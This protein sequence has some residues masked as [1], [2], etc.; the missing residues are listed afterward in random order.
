[1]FF[2]LI[3]ICKF[4]TM[5]III[6]KLGA[7]GDVARTLPI[8]PAL[9]QKF[10]QSE[11]YWVTKPESLELF[12]GNPYVKQVFSAPF[13]SSENFD[14]LCNF[15]I[16]D[17]ATLLAGEIQADKKYGFYSDS[18]YPAPFNLGSQYYL[19]TLFDD[20]LKK[21]N[22]K[23][24]Q[25]MIFEVAELEYKKQK[26]QIYL[27]EKDKS[28]AEEFLKKNNIS[29]ENLV[30]IHM[31]ASSRWPSKV[32]H[33]SE[34]SRFIEKLKERG[35]SVLLFGGPNE[36]KRHKEFAERLKKKNIK[37]FI[38]NPRNTLKEFASLV[39]LCKKI[40]C[41]DSLALHISLALKKPTM[42]LFFCT[43]PDE[44]EGY[45]IL[46]KIISPMLYEFFPEKSDKYSE[47]L[48]KSITAEQVLEAINEKSS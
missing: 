47:E 33:E 8:L 12:E 37:I 7:L 43:S 30:G 32:W 15:D 23:T 38:N 44:V 34:L 48:T 45:G 27:S 3:K 13:K 14:I 9:K 11:I 35:Y 40:V 28:Y 24:Y 17:E 1:M 19:N 22:K 5:R 21:S 20:E 41:S 25:E 6:I 4:N 46:T 26:C 31:G 36:E 16:D 10:P 18:G 39:S 42:A 29:P 2:K